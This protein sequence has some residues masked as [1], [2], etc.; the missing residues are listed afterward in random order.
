M[1]KKKTS[2]AQQPVTISDHAV[3]RYIERV[4]K[5]DVQRI[6]DEMLAG[7]RAGMIRAGCKDIRGDGYVLKV[8]NFTVITVLLNSGPQFP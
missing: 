1:A 4:L 8:K 5:I 3:L 7:D 2:P 6:R